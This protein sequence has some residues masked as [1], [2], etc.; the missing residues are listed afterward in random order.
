MEEER[1]GSR[2]QPPVWLWRAGRRGHGENVQG[3]ENR[4][5]AFPLRSR[6]HSGRTVSHITYY[7][8]GIPPCAQYMFY[9]VKLSLPRCR[10][11]NTAGHKRHTHLIT[12]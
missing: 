2:V 6:I 1:R 8:Y 11:E 4:A 9:N 3:V 7:T 5:G 10:E 12:E